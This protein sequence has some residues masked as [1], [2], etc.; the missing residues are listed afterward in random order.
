MSPVLNPFEFAHHW[1]L[2]MRELDETYLQSVQL[3][4]H[5]GDYTDGKPVTVD[6]KGKTIRL[7]LLSRTVR[8]KYA[9]VLMM[10][11]FV[12]VYVTFLVLAVK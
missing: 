11:I 8:M 7:G 3:M 6:A 10:A 12:A 5:G 2:S 1:T 4:I 9:A